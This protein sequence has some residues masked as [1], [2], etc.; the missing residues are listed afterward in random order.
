MVDIVRELTN[1][2]A[3]L[4][5]RMEAR[6]GRK[7]R[8]NRL[9]SRYHDASQ[10]LEE[11]GLTSKMSIPAGVRNTLRVPVGWCEKAVTVP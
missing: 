9:R 10:E 8:V 4:M 1:D 7:R 2:E 11:F 3:T 6:I 5:G